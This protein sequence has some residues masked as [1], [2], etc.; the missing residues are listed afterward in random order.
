MAQEI[1]EIS[2]TGGLDRK[3]VYFLRLFSEV[4][5]FTL[6]TYTKKKKLSL[7]YG[8]DVRCSLE[9]GWQ[10]GLPINGL[11]CTPSV[12]KGAESQESWENLWWRHGSPLR[13]WLWGFH[14]KKIKENYIKV[15]K[16]INV[17]FC[18]MSPRDHGL[19]MSLKLEFEP[20]CQLAV[21]VSGS[22]ISSHN[23]TGS[24]RSFFFSDTTSL[25]LLWRNIPVRKTLISSTLSK[26]RGLNS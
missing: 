14:S 17:W 1:L 23:A 12:S 9:S 10:S 7:K 26:N 19:L 16:C 24:Y 11:F 6:I 8:W 3:T 2:P 20:A 5:D 22:I 18:F 4:K 13:L 15:E 25:D 21:A